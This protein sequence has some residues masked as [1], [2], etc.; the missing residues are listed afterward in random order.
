MIILDRVRK[1]F[2]WFN[3]ILTEYGILLLILL[4]EFI[5]LHIFEL[6]YLKYQL[7]AP[8]LKSLLKGFYYDFLFLAIISLIILIPYVLLF[9]ISKKTSRIIFYIL[10]G[11]LV[12]IS[13]S[14]ID[15]LKFNFIPLDHAFF[16][17]PI[18]EL[19]YIVNKSIDLNFILFSKYFIG[20][21]LAI[22]LP[23]LFFKKI[24]TKQTAIIGLVFILSG[25]FFTKNLNP[26]RRDYPNEKEFNLTL[27]KLSFFAKSSAKY[28]IGKSEISVVEFNKI[29]S[30]YQKNHPKFDFYGL[31]YPLEHAQDTSNVLAPFFN[32]NSDP[33]NIV[34]VVMESLSSAFCGKNAYL[35]NF[36]PFLD[37]LINH[38]L[39]W[40]N[41]LST[42]E[43]TFNAIPSIT[44]SLPYGDKGFMQL[45]GDDFSVNH[46]SLLQVLNQNGYSSAFFYGGWTSFDN[47]KRY[48]EYQNTDFILENF[49]EEYNKIKKDKD[50]F[51]WG[52]PDMSVFERSFEVID[53]LNDS[54][55]VDLYLTLSL[56][57]PF[58]PPNKE[59]YDSLFIRQMNAQNLTKEEKQQTQSFS[60]ILATTLYTDDAMR[61]FINEYKTREDF[62]NTIFIITG[63][64]RLGSH[65]VKNP[66]DIYHV[67]LIIY[68]PLLKMS[69]TFSS[70]SSHANISPA[71]QALLYNKYDFE[72]PEK[73]HSLG[74]SIDTCQSF[75]NIHKLAFMRTSREITDYLSGEYFIS[76]D[77]L[78][79]LEKGLNLI[80]IEGNYLKDSLRKELNRFKLIN[81]YITKNNLLKSDN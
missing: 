34:I 36:T 72:V 21:G 40:E 79:K 42:S 50:G 68:S 20:I 74:I 5:L 62:N 15:Y 1:I 46:S 32:L 9:K 63:D 76:G 71:I 47:M 26:S 69:Q 59:Y 53:S 70:V 24:S 14:L 73:S 2:S 44:G 58:R 37:S 80:E 38:S 33:P 6:F 19:A 23:Y 17:Y 27:N 35:G 48:F 13:I 55:R 67:P 12:I 52:Y 8:I 66:I 39:Y 54:P 16:A 43:R 64:H 75:R 78:F 60:E 81:D 65:G 3:S 49:G 4:S 25:V 41:F 10:N 57:H 11:L 18:N 30:E 56:H 29:A 45:L 77:R 7:S 51:S 28:F 61:H 31:N 22:L